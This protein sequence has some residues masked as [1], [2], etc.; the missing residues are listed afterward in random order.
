MPDPSITVAVTGDYKALN[1][2][3]V[4]RNLRSE[5]FAPHQL[6]IAGEAGALNTEL[7]SAAAEA[8]CIIR[9]LTPSKNSL[10]QIFLDSVR[11][12]HRANT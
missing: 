8:R 12:G 4:R 6:R 2:V 5:T 7:W 1:E 3:L 11:E 10:E 9:S